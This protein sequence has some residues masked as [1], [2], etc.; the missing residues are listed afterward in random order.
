MPGREPAW[1]GVFQL[2]FLLRP[3]TL[4]STF[5]LTVDTCVRGAIVIRRFAAAHP[6]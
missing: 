3:A 1:G 2:R 4:A 5:D 6:A